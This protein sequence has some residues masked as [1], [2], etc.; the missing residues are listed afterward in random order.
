MK[1]PDFLPKIASLGKGLCAHVVSMR[2]S[3]VNIEILYT[4]QGR[5]L[6]LRLGPL[7][8]RIK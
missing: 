5:I 6:I 3:E 4:F 8:E 7:F 1:S 2:L